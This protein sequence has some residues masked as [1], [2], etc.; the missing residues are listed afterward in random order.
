[1]SSHVLCLIASDLEMGRCGHI[2]FYD[3]LDRPQI[4]TG[5]RAD[6]LRLMRFAGAHYLRCNP[7]ASHSLLAHAIPT[8]SPPLCDYIAEIF[9]LWMIGA[10][11]LAHYFSMGVT[12]TVITVSVVP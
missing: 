4:E 9:S 11:N 10:I 3:T 5:A 8:S 12:H 1:M 2:N 7:K 6:K